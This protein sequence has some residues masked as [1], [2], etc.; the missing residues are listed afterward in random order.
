[1][2]RLVDPEAG[3]EKGYSG[4]VTSVPRPV[5]Y[6]KLMLKVPDTEY[7]AS[8]I[9]RSKPFY[10][11]QKG[12]FTW[13][14]FAIVKVTDEASLRSGETIRKFEVPWPKGGQRRRRTYPRLTHSLPSHPRRWTHRRGRD[15]GALGPRG[16]RA[17]TRPQAALDAGR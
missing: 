1:M 6:S 14:R 5:H 13:K 11:R 8:R 4:N 10:D 3:E 17:A 16:P 2:P 12:M 15:V 9:V 7:Y